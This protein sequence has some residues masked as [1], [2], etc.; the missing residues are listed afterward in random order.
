MITDQF[1]PAQA[2]SKGLI[3]ALLLALFWL[4]FTASLSAEPCLGGD[5]FKSSCDNSIE[6]FDDIDLDD[7]VLVG[8]PTR[9]S[10][11]LFSTFIPASR[12]FEAGPTC[13][14]SPQVIRAPPVTAA[15]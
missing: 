3:Q 6:L 5:G 4:V 10:P 8:N 7:P 2:R 11:P 13:T 14:R 9:E 1:S 15:R 12:H